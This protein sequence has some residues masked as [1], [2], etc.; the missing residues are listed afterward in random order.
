MKKMD[1]DPDGLDIPSTPNT[2]TTNNKVDEH[3]TFEDA[4]PYQHNSDSKQEHTN[5]IPHTNKRADQH[6]TFGEVVP[7]SFLSILEL[8]CSASVS[9]RCIYVCICM[10]I[11]MCVCVC[12][13]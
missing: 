10:C 7:E 2:I 5:T 6:L 11:C 4:K 13:F 9:Y 8:A 3:Q 1:L 12:V